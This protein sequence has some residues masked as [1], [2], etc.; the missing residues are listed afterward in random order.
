MNI[1]NILKILFSILYNVF[2]V[3]SAYYTFKS[4]KADLT[5]SKTILFASLVLGI[6][7]EAA[8]KEETPTELRC[9]I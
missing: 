9:Y 7:K 3:V 2:N 1:F 6:F 5:S 8:V 4:L